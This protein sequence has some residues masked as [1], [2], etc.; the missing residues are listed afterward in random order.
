MTTQTHLLLELFTTSLFAPVFGRSTTKA[1]R[2]CRRLDSGWKHQVIEPNPG[3]A[4]GDDVEAQETT[5]INCKKWA[6]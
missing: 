2:T 4:A 5:G 1:R 6:T 3:G